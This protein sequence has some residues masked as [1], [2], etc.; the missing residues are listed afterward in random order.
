MQRHSFN[1]SNQLTR[2]SRPW[3]A[4]L[5]V[6]TILV[7]ASLGAAL[8]HVVRPIVSSSPLHVRMA[9]SAT[10][11]SSPVLTAQSEEAQII[12]VVKNDAP[13][14]VSI[15]ASGQVPKMERCGN[16]DPS[17]LP[18][19]FQ[20]YLDVPLYCQNGTQTERIGAGSG[21]IVS[22]DGYI[23]TNAHVVEDTKADYTVVL[24]DE[25]H[26][27]QKKSATVVARDTTN[28]IAIVKI[29]MSGLPFLAF[30]D[31]SKLQVGQTA[32]A[33]GYALGEFDNTVSKG[34][35]SGLSRTIT[36]DNVGRNNS[37]EELH[38]LIQTDAAINPGNSGGP[39]LDSSGHVI[40][41]NV[42]VADA[43]GIGF[44][45]P[46]NLARADFEQVKSTGKFVAPAKAFLGVRYQPVT[47]ELKATKRLPYDF[48]M[49]VQPGENGEPAVIPGS[50]A[51]RAGI[52][53]N[54]IITHMDGKQL[55]ER[56]TLSDAIATH[57]PGDTVQLTVNHAG[58]E[59]TLSVTLGK[60][61]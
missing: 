8:L 46:A 26:I 53:A 2:L 27:G 49:L 57:K 12:S 52:A 23:L 17:V 15:T 42:A 39:L 6:C 21:F 9:M 35:V 19:Q 38:G 48:G 59:K 41:M 25:A 60:G 40:G 20:G 54:D 13:A 44:A 4:A 33:I 28:D 51:D 58:R 11:P 47:T 24:N 31:S 45:V 16:G 43:Q 3:M 56:Y 18:P 55:N 37:S 32:I 34:V 29:D 7:T 36:A 14:V 22:S 5:L 61:S 30:G 50:P 1:I 10:A